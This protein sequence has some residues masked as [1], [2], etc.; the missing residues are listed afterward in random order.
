MKRDIKTQRH[1]WEKQKQY[2]H[3]EESDECE[4]YGDLDDQASAREKGESSNKVKSMPGLQKE[5]GEESIE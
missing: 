3:H 1:K 2:L 4:N 5:T